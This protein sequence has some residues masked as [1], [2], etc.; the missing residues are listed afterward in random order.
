MDY[1]F[2]CVCS[3]TLCSSAG[4]STMIY[5][6]NDGGREAAGYKGR[7][8][9]CVTRAIAIAADLPYKQ[10]YDTLL[11]SMR[12]KAKSKGR[13]LTTYP[14]D[15]I[16]DEV[17]APYLVTLGFKWVSSI[18]YLEDDDLPKEGKV[19]V[20]MKGHLCAA[21]N[22]VVHD[23]Y[24]CSRKGKRI[25]HGYYVKAATLAARKG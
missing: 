12:K 22:G 10:V 7:S 14:N 25:F 21:V 6:Y 20:S 18:G 24:D 11:Q 9:D 19:V 13:K 16:H 15:G 1:R 23:T 4:I 8:R 5:V 2:P 3:H 17:Y